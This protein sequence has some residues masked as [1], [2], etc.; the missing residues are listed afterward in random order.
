[1]HSFYKVR[2]QMAWTALLKEEACQRDTCRHPVSS[3]FERE[4]KGLCNPGVVAPFWALCAVVGTAAELQQA[5][6][7]QRLPVGLPDICTMLSLLEV[8]SLRMEAISLRTR[9]AR[10]PP[11]P[12]AADPLP[13]GASS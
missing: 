10:E 7:W 5:C 4:I 9:T 2:S 8:L 1:M 3:Q 6:S 11:G 12:A 13:A